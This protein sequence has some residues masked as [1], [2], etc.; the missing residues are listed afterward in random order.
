MRAPAAIRRSARWAVGVWALAAALVSP[1]ALSQDRRGKASIAELSTQVDQ[2]E[3][4]VKNAE[5]NLQVVEVQYTERPEPSEDES[6]ERRFSDGEI[7]YLLRD[8]PGASVLFYD[9]VADKRF[10]SHPRYGDA[11]FYLAD[12]LYQQ[13]NYVGAKVYLRELLALRAGHYREALARFLEIA[14]RLNEFAGIDEFIHQARGLSGG[15]LPP[16]I[17]YVYGKWLFKRTDLPLQERVKRAKAAL[18]PLASYDT[19]FRLQSAYFI[20]VGQ[21]RLKDY[22]AAIAQFKKISSSYGRGEKD[23][24]IKELANLSLGRLYYET[25]QYDA[26]LDR[27]QEIPRES[28]LFPDSLYEVAWTQVKKGEHERAKNATDILLL[29]APDST[30]APEAQLLQGHLLLKLKR[31]DE[32]SETYNS[33]INKFGPDHDEMDA[34]LKVQDPIK[35]FDDL[36]A[37]NDRN[38]DVTQLLPQTARKWATT[39]REVAEAYQLMNDLDLGRRG[40]EES[41]D[42]A[43]RIL[44][45]LEER[46]METFPAIQE[47]YTRADAIDSAL[48]QADGALVRIEGY[49]VSDELT[50]QEKA[51]LEKVRQES[52]ELRQKFETLPTTEREVEARRQRMRDRAD[53]VD[54]SAFK[55]GYEVQSMFAIITA[56]EKWLEDTKTERK[57][58]PEDEKAFYEKVKHE[59][60]VLTALTKDLDAVRQSIAEVKASADAVLEGE[61]LIRKQLTEAQKRQH[62][63]LLAAEAKLGP[64]AGKVMA[65]AHAVRDR[66]ERLR[67]R[68]VRAKAKLREQLSRKGRQIRD[69]V[70]AEQARLSDYSKEV[71]SVSDDARNLVGRITVDSFQRVRQQLYELVLKADVGVVDVAFTRKQDKTAQIQK[72]SAEKDRELRSLDNEFKE[73]LKDV[74]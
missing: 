27:Y 71:T 6:R 68:V 8:Y 61:S 62:Q 5:D 56:L 73:V 47:G 34:L 37:K 28:E 41:E 15:Q 70:G 43:Q 7:Q 18:E 2:V 63:L 60:D 24:K 44:R 33:V 54:R 67:E 58:S 65:K 36:L 4:Q 26:A 14:G 11:L 22:P 49:L 31:Y 19:P 59:I 25:G 57:S 10:R 12:S 1:A 69:T 23:L 53:E 39:Q 3:A 52:A 40:V 13:K 17:A 30:L 64:E 51:E 74:D 50:E 46:G 20:A 38:L 55:L 9:L 21:V 48:T 45:A 32:A 35:Y 42:I 72:L 16:E 66:G 29:V